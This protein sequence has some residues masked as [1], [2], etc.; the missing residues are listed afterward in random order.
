M[1]TVETY[2]KIKELAA[3]RPLK[4]IELDQSNDLYGHAYVLKRYSGV[5]EDYKIKATLQHA[6]LIYD[7]VWRS[8]II[9]PL[10]AIFTFSE[11]RFPYLRQ[12]TNKALFA[13]GPSIHYAKSEISD[14]ELKKTKQTLGKTLLVFLPH[15]AWSIYVYFDH[16]Q[17]IANIKRIEKEFNTILICLGW[18]DVLRGLEKPYVSEG[19]TCVTAGHVYDKKFLERLKTIIFISTH[20]MSFSFG[21][22]IGFCIHLK[23]PHWIPEPVKQNIRYPDKLPK[24]ALYK[25]ARINWGGTLDIIKNFKDLTDEITLK[26]KEVVDCIWGTPYVKS[27][28]KLRELFDITEDMFNL[29]YLPCD[30]ENPIMLCQVFDYI[31][32]NNLNKAEILLRYV[33]RVG[34][35]KEWLRFIKS[36]ILIAEKKF[37]QAEPIIKKLANGSNGFLKEKANQLLEVLDNKEIPFSLKDELVSLYPK[38]AFFSLIKPKFPWKK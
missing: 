28:K 11:Y 5:S 6:A 36:L 26:Q 16:N 4:T 18:R 9:E 29:K 20:T 17:I 19:Y 35:S 2:K 21:T 3:I 33:K 25:S 14:E 31:E 24:T 8:E 30:R 15:S 12:F 13:I 23:R 27:P 22:H 37:K 32:K 34:Y 7:H 10:P 1:E 38:P